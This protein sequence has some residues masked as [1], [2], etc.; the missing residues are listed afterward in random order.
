MGCIGQSDFNF[1]NQGRI[2]EKKLLIMTAFFTHWLV[3]AEILTAIAMQVVAVLFL[4]LTRR[5]TRKRLR[6]NTPFLSSQPLVAIIIPC[7]RNVS[8]L[9][10]NLTSY[11]RQ[12]YSN[13]EL[14]F[15]VDHES[16]RVARLVKKLIAENRFM[17]LHLV[18]NQR[19]PTASHVLSAWVTALQAAKSRVDIVAF[20]SCEN[21]VSTAWV[22]YLAVGLAESKVG[23][24]SGSVWTYPRTNAIG[25]K[26]MSMLANFEAVGRGALGGWNICAGSWGTR[27]T[28]IEQLDLIQVWR[29]AIDAN[30][31]TTHAIVNT[32]LRIRYEPQ[33]HAIQDVDARV[34][35]VIREVHRQS[36]LTR[37]EAILR[38]RGV[39]LVMLTIQNAY[40][41]SL[42]GGIYLATQFNWNAVTLVVLNAMLFAGG[43]ARCMLKYNICRMHLTDARRIRGARQ[44]EI[45][46]WPVLEGLA[47]VIRLSAYW[48]TDIRWGRF[49]YRIN[50]NGSGRLISRKPDPDVTLAYYDCQQAMEEEWSRRA[51]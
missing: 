44:L 36:V 37:A 39:N 18:V 24:V 35:G 32:G 38:W 42:V 23:A 27:G 31:T 25:S 50:P 34:K 5:A 29:N 21:R 51:A 15:V 10:E 7:L 3:Y 45:V 6:S 2:Q 20:G 8:G 9:R 48:L 1:D 47:F 33:C 4:I 26:L 19:E 43:L 41:I 22:R 14:Y 28:V 13:I 16:S 17:R 49:S 30:W 11:L 40:W 12:D 46:A